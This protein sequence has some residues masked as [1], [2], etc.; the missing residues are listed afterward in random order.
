[1]FDVFNEPYS[2]FADNGHAGLR[3]HLGVLARRRLQRPRAPTT[4]SRPTARPTRPSAAPR[5]S[6]RPSAAPAPA[7][8][9]CSAAATT[10]TTSASGSPG[11]PPTGR[12]P[13]RRELPQLQ[14]PGL[15]HDVVLGL[16]DR[17]DRRPG[18][19]HHH[20]VRPDRLPPGRHLDAYMNWADAARDRLP[21]VGLVGPARQGRAAALAL[22]ADQQASPR[23]PNGTALKAHLATLRPAAP[24]AR[25][26][27][28]AAPGRGGRGSGALQ[29]DLPPSRGSGKLAIASDPRRVFE[30]KTAVQERCPARRTATLSLRL[31]RGATRA[32]AQ[33]LRAGRKV[34]ATLTVTAS[35]RPGSA[36]IKQ[37]RVRLG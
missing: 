3:P 15:P 37:R 13:A 4:S 23:A 34:T 21:G 6:S 18:P 17:P 30:L 20:R 27:G 9:S 24:F 16:D 8:R 35:G 26:S 19:G 7:S 12:G 10:P 29:Q 25:R 28:R 31:S 22:L 5:G 11:G 14:E 33:A 36:Q 2:R 32:A 1:M